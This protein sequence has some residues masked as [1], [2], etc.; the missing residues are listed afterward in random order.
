MATT[1]KLVTPVTLCVGDRV[2]LTTDPMRAEGT[3]IRIDGVH[4]FVC[5]DR[6]RT[7]IYLHQE[8]DLVQLDAA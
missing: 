7:W 5:W 2:T 3:V 1:E 4:H 8:L 6:G